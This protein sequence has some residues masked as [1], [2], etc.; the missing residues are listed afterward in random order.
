MGGEAARGPI[1]AS[2]DDD[3]W[4]APWRLS[5]QVGAL[6]EFGADVVGLDNLLHY[7]PFA[8]RAWHSVRPSGRLPWMPGSTLCYTKAFWQSNP[9]PDIQPGEDIRFLRQKA[10]ANIV[11][12]QAITWLVDII[13]QAN[14]SPKPTDSPLW[15]PFSLEEMHKLLGADEAVYA[16]LAAGKN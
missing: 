16:R 9:F 8:R 12:L 15:F 14:V 7:D 11:A 4:A 3:V 5:Y 1:L 13:H 6:T 2:W 10:A